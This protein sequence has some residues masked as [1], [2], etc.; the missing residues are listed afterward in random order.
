MRGVKEMVNYSLSKNKLAKICTEL[1]ANYSN[2]KADN[3][4]GTD[5]KEWC[6]ADFSQTLVHQK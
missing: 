5:E 4:V 6:G 2:W 3:W 1:L